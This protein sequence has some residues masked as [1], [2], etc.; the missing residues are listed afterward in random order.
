MWKKLKFSQRY[1]KSKEGTKRPW[2]ESSMVRKVHKWYETSVV[3]KVYGTKSL[4]F[5]ENVPRF[6]LLRFPPVS[7][8]ATLSTP[9]FYA[10][11]V[12]SRTITLHGWWT[13]CWHPCVQCVVKCLGVVIDSQLT[14]ADSVKNLTK[15]SFYW[16]RQ[17]RTVRRSLINTDAAKT[18]LHALM[19]C[20]RVRFSMYWT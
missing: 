2:Y 10:P 14:F 18:L 17:L 8:R 5:V 20:S 16:L 12:N 6:P 9:A 3:R 11:P 15:S 4:A 13:W 19:I 1:E 7:P